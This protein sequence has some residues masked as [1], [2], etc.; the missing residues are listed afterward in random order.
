MQ[1]P[2]IAI[3]VPT[4]VS[5]AW[6]SPDAIIRVTFSGA[7]PVFVTVTLCAALTLFIGWS[8]NETVVRDSVTAALTG[9]AAVNNGI[10]Q[11]PLP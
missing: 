9:A 5:L 10:C 6:N 3:V 1:L 4:Q 11:I 2:L 7:A 8:P